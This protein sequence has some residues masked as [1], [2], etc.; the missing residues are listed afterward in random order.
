MAY[1]F[2]F[3]GVDMSA[4]GLRLLSPSMPVTRSAEQAQLKDKAYS[5]APTYPPKSITLECVII[6]SSHAD[7][8]DKLDAVNRTL[9]TRASAQLIL[10]SISDRYILA[11][12]QDISGTYE[13]ATVYRCT[14]ACSCADP[15]AY[16]VSETESNHNIDAD[17]KTVTET[18]EGTEYIEP[19]YLLTA[20][21]ALTD[22][23]IT[24]ESLETLEALQWTGSLIMNDT[25]EIDVAGWIVKKNGVASMAT[26]SGQFPR[27]LPSQDNDIKVTGFSTTG[28]LKIT[29]RNKYL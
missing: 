4:Y 26:V 10:D 14:I 2:S 22:V 15:V 29:Y 20:G 17:P 3:D 23:T 11:L 8:T 25:L 7:L 12:C 9:N 1:S 19:V 28:T 27:L 24:V 18:A 21:E 5:F 13:T 16:A 6:G